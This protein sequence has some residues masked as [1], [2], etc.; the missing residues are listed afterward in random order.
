MENHKKR[1][2]VHDVSGF[3]SYTNVDLSE[4]LPLF[5]KFLAVNKVPNIQCVASDNLDDLDEYDLLI[6]NYAFAEIDREEQMAYLR[7][8]I[9]ATPRGYVTYNNPNRYGLNPM[10]LDEFVSLLSQEGRSIE[11]MSEDPLTGAGNQVVIWRPTIEA[12]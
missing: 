1:K 12:L 6:S 7:K 11:V 2:M 10:P 8:A 3:S 9:I 5:L 4:C